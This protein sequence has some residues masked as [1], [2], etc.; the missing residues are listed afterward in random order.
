MGLIVKKWLP[1]GNEGKLLEHLASLYSGVSRDVY[2]LHDVLLATKSGV[3]F[4]PDFILVDPELG[5]AVIEEKSYLEIN[6]KEIDAEKVYFKDGNIDVNPIRKGED[7]THNL[8]NLLR[9]EGIKVS[10]RSISCHIIFSNLP[11]GKLDPLPSHFV[12]KHYRGYSETLSLKT[13]FTEPSSLGQKALRISHLLSP[14][15]SFSN[16]AKELSSHL[17]SIAA[18]DEKQVSVV[19][20]NPY[21]HYLVSGIPGSGKSVV[22]V[23]RALYLQELHP[24]WKILILS[25]NE[26]LR[27]KN[28][29][30]LHSRMRLHKSLELQDGIS[31]QTL[32]GFLKRESG[33]TPQV[34]DYTGQLKAY[35]R[36]LQSK[37]ITPKWDAILIDEYQD[38]EDE[39]LEQI[40]RFGRKMGM[41]I[42]KKT[43]IRE[44]L[45]LVG[46]KLQQI[47]EK[48]CS[49]SWKS[50]GIHISGRTTNL[51]TSYRCGKQGLN[52]GLT[53]LKTS[54]T[55][56]RSQV[57][58]F[59]EGTNDIDFL[60]SSEF[61]ITF[62]EASW[63]DADFELKRWIL[64]LV[65]DGAKYSDILVIVPDNK[66]TLEELSS[67]LNS[68]VQQGLVIGMPS[69]IKGL[70]S[71]F[72]AIYNLDFI[73]PLKW[74]SEAVKL[75]TL[76]MCLTRASYGLFI[77]SFDPKD[78]VF[79]KLQSI[80]HDQMNPGWGKK[81]SR[82][83]FG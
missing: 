15:L 64:K 57:E 28:E 26:K 62:S 40:M 54:K 63:Q 33:I 80:H 72:C 46:D 18:L 31:C 30:Q 78:E 22:V 3:R 81:V 2:L 25:V 68:E 37:K 23:S 49:H 38:F 10:A 69:T 5:I 6:L 13:L 82:L 43:V 8:Q 53:L 11:E 41:T 17:D 24:E 48:G 52:L 67:K 20:Q 66:K 70:E 76:Y 56:L 65:S 21:G 47:W 42:N 60:L 34:K 35:V 27:V 77:N 36:N 73:K 14:V 32:M 61:P 50:L 44:N 4:R 29:D 39:V 19:L 59:Y 55:G 83:F 75:R 45:F 51:K 74:H 7:Y 58:D 71:P 16:A 1:D 9:A 79:E 12:K